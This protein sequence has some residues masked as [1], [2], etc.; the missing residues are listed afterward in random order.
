LDF[1]PSEEIACRHAQMPGNMAIPAN[2]TVLP[3]RAAQRGQPVVDAARAGAS[4]V[5]S[6]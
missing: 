3:W 2:G 6:P 4:R 1:K 5:V